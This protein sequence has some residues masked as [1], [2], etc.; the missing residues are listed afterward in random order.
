M[1]SIVGALVL[2]AGSMASAGSP[3]A[4]DAAIVVDSTSDV[5]DFGGARQVGD[6]PGPDGQVTLR[7]AITAANNT[8]GPN[9]IVFAIPTNDPG[10]IGDEFFLFVEGTPLVVTDGATTIDATTQVTLTGHRVHI[11]T[12]PP[13]ANLNGL[14]INSSGNRLTGLAGMA[15]FRYG[16]EL[17]GNNN[18]VSGS[19]LVHAMSASIHVTGANNVIGGTTPGAGNA[20]RSSGG[21]GVWIRGTRATGNVVQGNLITGHHFR[22]VSIGDGAAGN[23]L[24]GTTAAARNVINTNG[25]A[26]SQRNPVGAQVAVAGSNNV[27][28]GNH[29]GVDASGTQAAGGMAYSGVLVEGTGNRIGGTT[30]G[31]GNVISGQGVVSPQLANR[32]AGIRVNGGSGIVIQGNRIGTD[33]SGT[34]PIPNQIGIHVADI[35]FDGAPTGI[36]IGG[37]APGA[38]NIVAFNQMDGIAVQETGQPPF[39]VTISRN[40]IFDNGELG[41]DLAD[42]PLTEQYPAAV[43]PNDPGDGDDGA[44][45]LQN[46]PVLAAA[47]DDGQA[48]TVTGSLDTPNPQLATVEL[49]TGPVA[50]PSGFG[51]GRVFR[52]AVAPDA[53]GTFSAVLPAGTTGFV[54]ATATDAAGNT[55]EFSAAVAITTGNPPGNPPG[56]PTLRAGDIDLRARVRRGVAT[57]TA[58]VTVLDGRGQPVPNAVVS[59][60]WTRPGGTI[61]AGTATTGSTGRAVLTTRA[62]RGTYTLTVD[63]I[64]KPGHVFDTAGSV[65]TASIT[66]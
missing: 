61:A 33:G 1:R 35:F 63:A 11:R 28:T 12:T 52:T 53:A 41:I 18:V 58:T 44:N 26:S 60:T 13:F 22:G 45:R 16:I 15:L 5:S 20:F 66:T 54:T 31:S 38:G 4:Q 51:E 27:V 19:M 17:N 57:V 6:L 62:G 9:T 36:L 43:T 3:N 8:A 14:T 30:A 47:V 7:E 65:R 46:F 2:A 37:S 40:S 50:D 25:H 42:R 64:D 55:S 59:A 32:P 10:L 23:T 29:I 24:G 49:F 56:E 21:D 39:S 48:V 34:S